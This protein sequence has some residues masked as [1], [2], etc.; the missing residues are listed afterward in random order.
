M[1]SRNI[2]KK[3]TVW[4]CSVCNSYATVSSDA[5]MI[6]QAIEQSIREQIS[7]FLDIIHSK[8]GLNFEVIAQRLGY[9]PSYIS[10][11]RQK[12]ATPAFKLWNQLKSIAI[13]PQLE[14]MNLDPDYNILEHN[15]LLRA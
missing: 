1:Y 11:L 5:Q 6:D 14:M 9:S 12:N 8:S 13:N 2:T 3:P 4:V 10:T 15:L 7:Q